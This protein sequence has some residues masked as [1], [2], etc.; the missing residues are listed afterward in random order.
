M[1]AEENGGA[2]A[3]SRYGQRAYVSAAAESSRVDCCRVSVAEHFV[4]Q[5]NYT[6][7]I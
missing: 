1:R 2:R 6:D 5:T 3:G 4:G 7:L